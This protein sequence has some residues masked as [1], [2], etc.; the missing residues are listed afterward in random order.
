MAGLV[1]EV[2]AHIRTV[3]LTLCHSLFGLLPASRPFD[4]TRLATL[5]TLFELDLIGNAFLL[6][7]GEIELLFWT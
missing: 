6:N 5:P 4:P 2:P 1:A 7:V 3:E